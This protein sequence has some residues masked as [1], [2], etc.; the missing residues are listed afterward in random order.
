MPRTDVTVTR[1]EL[2]SIAANAR[3]LQIDVDELRERYRAERD[4]RFN[5]R[6]SGQFHPIAA[7]NEYS[8]FDRDPWAPEIE[9]RPPMTETLDVLIIGGG[10]GGLGAATRLV[11]AGIDNLRVVEVAAD[12]GGTWYW[13]R[14]PGVRCDI[15]SYIYLPF[16]EETGFVPAD[17]YS[18]GGEILEYCR[19]LGRTFGIYDKAV[20]QTRVVGIEWLN[21]EQRYRVATDRGD[22]FLAR[23]VITQSGIFSRPQLPGIPGIDDFEGDSF[24]T[25]RW[26]YDVTGGDATGSLDRLVGR[27]VGII[28]TGATGVQVIPQLARAADRVI[29]FQRTPTYIAPRGNGPT[30]RESFAALAPGWQQ[31]W[32]DTFDRITTLLDGLNC[33]INDGWTAFGRHQAAALQEIGSRLD[34]DARAA[35]LEASD[36]AW[37]QELRNW[38]DRTVHDPHKAAVL[39]AYYRTHCK[40]PGFSDEYLE[41]FNSPN[42]TVLDVSATPI[43]RITPKGVVV[44]DT[45]YELD[46][47]IHATGFDLGH[48]W[49]E[50]AGY[51]VVGR[52][53]TRLSE[54]W[55]TGSVAFHGLLA[56]DFPNMFFMGV[57]QTSGTPN[58]AGLL[59]QQAVHIAHLLEHMRRHGSTTIE[60]EQAAQDEW[61]RMVLERAAP[62]AAALAECTPG[63]FNNEGEPGKT[64]V[65]GPNRFAPAVELYQLL[66][67]WREDGRFE[68]VRIAGPEPRAA[69]S[70]EP[71]PDGTD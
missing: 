20:F 28:G 33:P 24:H 3:R 60:V 41:A 49:T 58:F 10:F 7:T 31:Q 15:E 46:V 2:E 39:K 8:R 48:T 21:A 71:L 65:L 54:R 44:G 13:N 27:R 53:G 25:S 51:D 37:N 64:S 40:R 42:L 9:P 36:L 4:R 56:R 14:Y 22:T 57:T 62:R 61:Q 43:D 59:V 47:L 35:A 34:P 16:L 55:R 66:A 50:R 23:F 30:D 26:D 6:G 67:K 63:Y 52:N 5:P 1:S 45:E 69:S 29:V 18:T 32:I 68:G 19:L 11:K 38:V 17:K 70:G 12:F